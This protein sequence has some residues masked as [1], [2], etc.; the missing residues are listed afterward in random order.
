VANIHIMCACNKELGR[1]RISTIGTAYNEKTA[2][3][4]ALENIFNDNCT[5]IHSIVSI[6]SES[7]ESFVTLII[8]L[9]L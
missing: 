1:Y 7:F 2:I 9:H 6:I 5:I 8:W 4:I 3:M